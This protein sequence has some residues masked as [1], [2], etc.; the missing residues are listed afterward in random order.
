MLF[1]SA[2]EALLLM[3]AQGGSFW[4]AATHIHADSLPITVLTHINVPAGSITVSSSP[5]HVKPARASTSNADRQYVAT[6]GTKRAQAQQEDYPSPLP[7]AKQ[8]GFRSSRA[9][10]DG[11]RIL[12]DVS[13]NIL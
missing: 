5:A 13:A 1:P 4:L 12:A 6:R 8:K 10:P 2:P 11:L 9:R 7:K 3:K